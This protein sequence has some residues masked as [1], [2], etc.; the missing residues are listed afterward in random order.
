M[1]YAHIL[2]FSLYHLGVHEGS[3][4]DLVNNEADE[5][6]YFVNIYENLTLPCFP[7]TEEYAQVCSL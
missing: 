5:G 7:H 3:G 4:H 6:S 1:N 2:Y